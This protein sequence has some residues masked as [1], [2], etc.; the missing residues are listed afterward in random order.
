MLHGSPPNFSGKTRK[1]FAMTYIDAEARLFPGVVKRAEGGKLGGK[2]KEAGGE[3]G[4]PAGVRQRFDGEDKESWAGW[5]R[6]E[7]GERISSCA[8]PVLSSRRLAG[9]N[10]ESGPTAPVRYMSVSEMA[11]M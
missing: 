8:L 3:E 5:V 11:Q 1:A 6:G 4:L 7:A 9:G 2:V 10:G